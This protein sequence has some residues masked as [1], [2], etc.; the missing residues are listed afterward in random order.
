MSI[1]IMNSAILFQGA[2]SVM[3]F[4]AKNAFRVLTTGMFDLLKIKKR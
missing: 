2:P 4:G 3:S 1:G